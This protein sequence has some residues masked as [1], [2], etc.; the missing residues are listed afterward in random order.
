MAQSGL[1]LDSLS[2]HMY[3]SAFPLAPCPYVSSYCPLLHLNMN[4]LRIGNFHYQVE[5]QMYGGWM[6][7]PKLAPMWDTSNVG[8]YKE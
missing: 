2:L 7:K 8:A 3:S 1:K 5:T 6:G 4:L